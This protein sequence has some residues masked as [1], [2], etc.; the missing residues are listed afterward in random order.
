MT[1]TSGI[2]SERQAGARGRAEDRLI[3][4]AW[5]VALVATFGALFVGEV[6][7][8]A[9]CV[10]CWYQ[11]V[12]MFPLAVMLAIAC[13]RSD[14]GIWRYTLP[15]AGL[16][17]LV[18]AYH[19]LIYFGVINEA[20]VPC[21]STGPSCSSPDMTILNGLPMPLLSLVVFSMIAALLALIPRRQAA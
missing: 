18:A 8:Q 15:L 1:A 9:P 21:S 6:M 10:L 20:L 4:A 19:N 7:G 13:Y 16:G 5:I 14:A 3:F 2:P 11:R 17:W 12:F